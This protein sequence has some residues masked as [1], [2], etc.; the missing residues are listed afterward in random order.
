LIVLYRRIKQ[1]SQDHDPSKLYL[2]LGQKS[3]AG[4]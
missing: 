3:G 4:H 2:S 1:A